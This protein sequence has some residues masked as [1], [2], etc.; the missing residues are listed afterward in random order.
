MSTMW[1]YVQNGKRQGP[2][3]FDE[4]LKLYKENKL[5][6]EDYVWTKGFDNWTKI[7]DLDEFNSPSQESIGEFII[8]EDKKDSST[9]WDLTELK[10]DINIVFIR[11][12]IDRG[13]ASQE[14]GPFS[15]DLLLKLFDENRINGKTQVF[16]QGMPDWMFLCEMPG[17][18]QIFHR[19]PPIIE[20]SERRQNVRKPFIARMFIQ[21]DEQ[22]VEGICRDVSIGGMQV[23]VDNF[24]TN[25]G[26]EISINVHPE[27]SDHCFV[28]SGKVV[29]LLEGNLGFSFRFINLGDDA[30]TAIN[31]YLEQF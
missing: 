24:P 9:I 25:V 2:I 4:V 12:G 11:I 18:E 27:N 22:V 30:I 15:I 29:R 7:K 3:D 23:L 5:G 20:E 21:N 26:D 19:M 28:A 14:Y 8:E 10:T 13:V 16:I 17:F 31:K 1:Y 6:D